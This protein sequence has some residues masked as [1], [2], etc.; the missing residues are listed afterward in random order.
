MQI[1]D[2]GTTTTGVGVGLGA[3]DVYGEPR[4]DQA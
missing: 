1:G 4:S 3:G 2:V